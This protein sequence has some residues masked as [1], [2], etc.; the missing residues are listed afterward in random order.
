MGDSN[1]PDLTEALV[2]ARKQAGLT[3]GKMA[4]I[5]GIMQPTV[6]ARERGQ[7][8]V[9]AEDLEKIAAATGL[10]IIVGPHG[11]SVGR[12]APEIRSDAWRDDKPPEDAV[13]QTR[14]RVFGRVSAGPGILNEDD[15][16]WFDWLGA[17]RQHVDGIAQV[18]G[19]SM[20][21][22]L[23]DQDIVG[24]RLGEQPTY[25]DLVVV[26]NGWDDQVQIKAWGGMPSQAQVSLLSLNP[27]Y[28]PQGY[29]LSDIQILGLAVGL[30][31]LG[32][33]R[34]PW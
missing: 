21:P 18:A 30:L 13:Y 2:E 17:W 7:S 27:R 26:R 5:C 15:D 24:V 19:D 28:A 10:H 32:K 6:S 22:V 12:A 33:L 29:H 14:L 11:W 8:T 4:E 20:E 9:P 34:A 1:M 23:F 3:Q 16:M 31:R 25:G